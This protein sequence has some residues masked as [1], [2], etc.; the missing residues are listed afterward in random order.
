MLRQTLAENLKRLRKAR[1][2]SQREVAERAG[3]S[4]SFVSGV[5]RTAVNISLDNIGALA[6]VFGVQPYVLLIPPRDDIYN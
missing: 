3:L 6:K 2:M 5:E 4:K 1:Q